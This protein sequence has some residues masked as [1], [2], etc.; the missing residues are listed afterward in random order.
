MLYT[1]AQAVAV[2]SDNRELYDRVQKN[3]MTDD[4]S[5]GASARSYRN[6][7]ASIVG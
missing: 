4:F 2:Y 3:G 7:Y 6:I 5:W 1:I